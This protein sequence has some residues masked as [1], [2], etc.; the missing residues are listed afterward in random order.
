M[1][2]RLNGLLRSRPQHNHCVSTKNPTVLTGAHAIDVSSAGLRHCIARRKCDLL[3]VTSDVLLGSRSADG[4]TAA[5]GDRSRE[6]G[7][8]GRQRMG[9]KLS[10]LAGVQLKPGYDV[11]ADALHG[12]RRRCP[13]ER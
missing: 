3:I 13:G 12:D 8:A 1:L 11:W 2:A 4:V 10:S 9:G 7:S 6:Q 5:V